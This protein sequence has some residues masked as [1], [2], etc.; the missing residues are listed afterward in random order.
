MP[1]DDNAEALK[2]AAA[3]AALNAALAGDKES[4]AKALDFLEHLN[5]KTQQ[6]KRND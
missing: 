1:G 3:Q 5:A 2:D 4:A 6:Q